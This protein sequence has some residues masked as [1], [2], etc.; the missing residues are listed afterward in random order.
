[1]TSLSDSGFSQRLRKKR[2]LKRDIRTVS[3]NAYPLT[4]VIDHVRLHGDEISKDVEVRRETLLVSVKVQYPDR[5]S[6]L[7]RNWNYKK[8]TYWLDKRNDRKL[9]KPVE[10]LVKKVQKEVCRETKKLKPTEVIVEIYRSEHFDNGAHVVM[11]IASHPRKGKKR[12]SLSDSNPL[13][14]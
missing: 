2:G 4:Q 9:V 10:W 3:L 14:N 1:M 13:Q 5:G 7:T 6:K 8:L 11:S 12:K